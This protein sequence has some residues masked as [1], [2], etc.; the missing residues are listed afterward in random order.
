MRLLIAD[1]ERFIREGMQ[2]VPW[3]EIGVQVCGV[4]ENGL[5]AL[6]LAKQH[7][8]DILLTDIRMPGMDG[9][10]LAKAVREKCPECALVILTGYNDFD[11][12]RQA[13]RLG[14]FDYILKPTSP[15]EI[16]ECIQNAITSQQKRISE[17]L[18]KQDDALVPKEDGQ[19]RTLGSSLGLILQYL[20]QNHARELTLSDVA[21]AFHFNPIYINRV[22]KR[23][24]GHTFLDIL[25]T[26]RLQRA[27]R[28]LTVS[29]DSIA[30]IAERVGLSNQ[31][32]FSQVFK[33][34]YDTSPLKYRQLARSGKNWA[35][36]FRDKE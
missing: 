7:N 31:K 20:E 10:Q 24:T 33:K 11:Y 28:L 2:T 3:H 34:A 14:V 15:R 26:I 30:E 23:E 29:D 12:A 13:L 22:L 36:L 19:A 4:A 16:L 17:A 8:P 21:E 5:H 6:E 27:V 9:L 32:Y 35:G 1:D 18:E 25:N